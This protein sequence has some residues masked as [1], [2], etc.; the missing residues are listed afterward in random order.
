MTTITVKVPELLNRKLQT[1]AE[2]CGVSK[3]VLMRNALE[4]YLEKDVPTPS[5]TTA[6]D[7]LKENIGQVVGPSDLSSKKRYMRGYGA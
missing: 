6:Y 3:S 5:Q 1:V 4:S 2:K 7:L